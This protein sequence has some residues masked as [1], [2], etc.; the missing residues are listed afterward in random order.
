LTVS[1]LPVT[2]VTTRAAGQVRPG[3]NDV[4]RAGSG[5][6]GVS[7]HAAPSRTRAARNGARLR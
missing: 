7:A 5:C 2:P 4:H 3:A 6:V 1:E